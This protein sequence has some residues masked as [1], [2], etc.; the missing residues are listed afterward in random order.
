MKAAALCHEDRRAVRW[1]VAVLVGVLHAAFFQ[2]VSMNPRAPLKTV[3]QAPAMRI[4]FVESVFRPSAQSSSLPGQERKRLTASYTRT[5]VVGE[6]PM[7]AARASEQSQPGV[8]PRPGGPIAS[9]AALNLEWTEPVAS[10]E[11]F[12]PGVAADRIPP[13]M[14]TSAPNRFRM[15]KRISGKDVVEGTAQLLGL[16]PP[17][18]TT[19]PCPTIRRNIGELMTDTRAGAR[20]LLDEELWKQQAYCP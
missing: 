14:R 15:R 19:D 3:P 7:A 6:T 2:I 10:H 9:S 17:G 16:W 11:D 4:R 5:P 20:A 12:R 18:Y 8:S 1:W 13:A